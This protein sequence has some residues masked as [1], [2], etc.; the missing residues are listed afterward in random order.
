MSLCECGCGTTTRLATRTYS[1]KGHVKGQPLRFVNGHNQRLNVGERH[2]HW[3]GDAV[4]YMGVHNWLRR[5]KPKAGACSNCGRV[6]RT[7]W[8]NIS[9]EY[10][11]DFDDYLE[12]CRSCHIRADRGSPTIGAQLTAML[13][14]V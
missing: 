4:G 1:S 10:R 6:G 9:G 3:K 14:A 11:R 13:A 7:D 8:A 5:H 12:L 2:Q